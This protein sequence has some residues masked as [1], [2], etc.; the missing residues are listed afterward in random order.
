[1]ILYTFQEGRGI[2][3]PAKIAA[4]D[5]QER[6]GLDTVDANLALGL[7]DEARDYTFA[8]GI[9]EQLGLISTV[10]APENATSDTSSRV[11]DI[12]LLSNNP[13]K[14]KRLEQALGFPICGRIPIMNEAMR[15]CKEGGPD[16]FVSSGYLRTKIERM[17]H[18]MG[19]DDGKDASD[20]SSVVCAT[21]CHTNET[22]GVHLPL[23]TAHS[24]MDIMPGSVMKH[25][26]PLDLAV[27]AWA[28][29]FKK[30]N[31]ESMIMGD[32]Q[33]PFVTL[34]FACGLDGCIGRRVRSSDSH[35]SGRLIVSG[36][37][38]NRLTHCLRRGH[39]AILVGIGTLLADNPKLTA[40]G[41]NGEIESMLKRAGLISDSCSRLSA[42]KNDARREGR[43]TF[44]ACFSL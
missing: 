40:R 4:Y 3:L 9:F 14:V 5:L 7:P 8:R 31:T 16:A 33:Y 41:V 30:Y 15:R 22:N 36:N 28:K 38:S 25:S 6:E 10:R 35:Q 43:H 20:C 39:D 21:D 12:H 27:E 18:K 37:E 32:K 24:R 17:G 19:D 1:M 34:S 23:S 13:E 11:C 26:S 42:R 2:G 44:E 29:S